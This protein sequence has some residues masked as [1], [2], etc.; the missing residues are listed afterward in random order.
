NVTVSLMSLKLGYLLRH[1]PGRT[2]TDHLR[3][4]ADIGILVGKAEDKAFTTKVEQS[5]VLR[6]IG[7]DQG[8]LDL[9]PSVWSPESLKFQAFG[10]IRLEVTEMDFVSEH[11]GGRYIPFS[12]G[13][14][15]FS[16]V[17]GHPPEET[18]H[19]GSPLEPPSVRPPGDGAGLRFRRLRLR[20]GGSEQAAE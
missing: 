16:G 4:L 17:H 12:G 14:S 8:E 19:P 3:V 15:V 5:V 2:W 18:F 7:W 6:D 20:T 9:F 1:V 13:I 10:V 11:N